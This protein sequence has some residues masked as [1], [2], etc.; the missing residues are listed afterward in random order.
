MITQIK[1]YDSVYGNQLNHKIQTSWYK[2]EVWLLNN[3]TDAI[4]YV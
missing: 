1:S 2:Y 4:T 3:E